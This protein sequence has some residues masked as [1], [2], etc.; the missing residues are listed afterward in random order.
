MQSDAKNWPWLSL[1]LKRPGTFSA[2]ASKPPT[3]TNGAVFVPWRGELR[4][5]RCE[6]TTGH[7]ARTS[8]SEI[9]H[10]GRAS[11]SSAPDPLS[12]FGAGRP[13][14]LTM[15]TSGSAVLS[16]GAPSALTH[17]WRRA[18]ASPS[19]S[20]DAGPPMPAGPIA[21]GDASSTTG[22]NPDLLQVQGTSSTAIRTPGSLSPLVEAPLRRPSHCGD[23]DG[24]D[25]HELGDRSP[26]AQRAISLSFTKPTCKVVSNAAQ[27]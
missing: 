23:D 4:V 19:A 18:S 6:R 11:A 5:R 14:S 20:S 13:A 25:G 22:D 8:G 27:S 17:I 10:G 9:M 1:R 16:P 2:I 12:S 21:L 26:T 7:G 15:S 3:V 24:T